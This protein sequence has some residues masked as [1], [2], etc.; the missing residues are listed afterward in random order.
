MNKRKRISLIVIGIIVTIVIIFS[1][2]ANSIA[3]NKIEALLKNNIPDHIENSYKSISVN[4]LGGSISFKD[5]NLLIKVKDTSLI[6]ANIKMESFTIGGLSYWDYLFNDEIHIGKLK[7]DALQLTYYKD[8]KNQA[9]DSTIKDKPF[10]LPKPIIIDKINFKNSRV[11][12][13][14]NSKDSTLLSSK[15]INLDINDILL[16]ENTLSN[17]IPID[18]G[19]I[20]IKTEDIFFKVGIYENLNIAQIE[21][22]NN[23]ISIK[24]ILLKTKYSKT[25]LSK[26]ITKERDHIDVNIGE[27]KINPINFGFEND[28]L[29]IN[30]KLITINNP[31]AAFYRDKL[32]RDDL[33]V[34]KLYSKSIRE[35]PIK[36]TVD[37][38]AISNGKVAYSEKVHAENPAGTLILSDLNG[39]IT[40]LSNTYSSPKKTTINVDGIFM[41]DTP[42]N[43]SWSFDINQTND[44]FTFKGHLGKLE[45]SDMNA[46]ITPL[47]NAELEGDIFETYF[48][49]TGDFNQSII[50]L[51][52]NYDSIKLDLLN[53]KRKKMK[54]LSE[55][56]NVFIN[57]DSQVGDDVFHNVTANASRDKTKS[58][59]NYL[60][61]NLKASLLIMFTKKNKTEKQKTNKHK[62][63][64]KA[65]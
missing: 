24:D 19:D 7:F 36:L 6:R 46:F 35:L 9:K 2:F 60:A 39:G 61:R 51:S 42:M 45:A 30:S 31:D 1:L 47:I 55:I 4:V 37:S 34:K 53:K 43:A 18:Y 3:K 14:E 32:V 15:I 8:H 50:H 28:T 59:F 5:L 65:N 33:K 25:E 10:K 62:D 48:E 27:L 11:S 57:D 54:T 12:I 40:N 13:F 29:F 38:I 23:N 44:A 17:R 58:F 41:N 22:E 49:I 20:L 26:I 52:Q 56:A 64:K 16:N 63:R 21:I